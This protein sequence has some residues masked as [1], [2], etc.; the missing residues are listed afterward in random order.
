MSEALS[1]P[2][3]VTSRRVNCPLLADSP[4][5]P[6]VAV[7]SLET[8]AHGAHRPEG[9]VV[10]RVPRVGAHRLYQRLT[11]WVCAPASLAVAA[12]ALGAVE[13]AASLDATLWCEVFLARVA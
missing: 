8:C 11:N 7:A 1:W 13:L 9:H 12:A 2:V 3:V 6:K 10:M 5:W 4:R